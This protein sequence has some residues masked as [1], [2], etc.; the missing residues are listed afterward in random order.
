MNEID[1]KGLDLEAN[2]DELAAAHEAAVSLPADG[3]AEESGEE[4]EK[5]EGSEEDKEAKEEAGEE[6]SGEEE[7][8]DSDEDDSDDATEKDLTHAQKSWFGRKIKGAV[9]DAT[10]TIHAENSEL[11]DTVD[12][13]V[14]ELRAMKKDDEPE[15]T[16]SDDDIITRGDLKKMFADIQS[17]TVEEAKRTDAEKQQFE[18][19]YLKRI[20]DLEDTVDADQFK[21]LE[22]RLTDHGSKF[23]V[24]RHSDPDQDFEHNLSD[25]M[26]DYM[27]NKGKEK[28]P[29]LKGD[30][31][32]GKGVGGDSKVEKK[33]TPGKADIT[34]PEALEFLASLKVRDVDTNALVKSASTRVMS[35]GMEKE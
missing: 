11:K 22:K 20:A 32:K 12:Q 1:D 30:K 34:D 7:S 17:R 19:R 14:G 29:K 33:D 31:A 10:K 16:G 13:L 24:I 5:A 18:E 9:E 27:S 4:E 23:N 2:L 35:P 15:D 25:A 3:P 21:E 28:K 8:E 26:L 6:E